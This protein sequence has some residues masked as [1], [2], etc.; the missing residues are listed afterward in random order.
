MCFYANLGRQFVKT[1]NFG[2]HLYPV[3]LGFFPDF[4]QIKLLQ[5]RLYPLNP[6]LQQHC[7]SLQ[8]H[9]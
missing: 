2:R 8:Y 6:K 5:V 7:F 1:S 9:W 4:H 3:F